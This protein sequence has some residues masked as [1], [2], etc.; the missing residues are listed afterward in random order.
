M[1]CFRYVLIL[2]SVTS[3]QFPKFRPFFNPSLNIQFN[4]NFPS[5]LLRGMFS[6]WTFYVNSSLDILQV[7]NKICCSRYHENIRNLI[8]HALTRGGNETSRPVHVILCLLYKHCTNCKFH[9]VLLTRVICNWRNFV[10]NNNE[11]T[12]SFCHS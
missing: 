11:F 1:G 12:I 4:R 9:C 5:H 10:S 7:N 3:L 6:L 2:L 8:F